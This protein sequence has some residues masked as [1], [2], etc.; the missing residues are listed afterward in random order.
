MIGRLKEN[1]IEQVLHQQVLGRL[2]CHADD[3]TYIVPISFAYD[4]QYIYV[5]TNE[6][7]KV[8]MMRKNPKVCF[9]TDAMLNMANWKTVIAWG[10]FEEL[11]N[12]EERRY[13]LQCLIDRV[14]PIISSETTHLFPHWPFP[15]DDVNEIKGVVFRVKLENKSGRFER[16]D[17]SKTSS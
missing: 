1:E 8:Q 11:N 12:E 15:P 7:R 14:I 16:N 13:A 3:V 17:V 9:E 4:G 10:K 6:G 2:G 5:H